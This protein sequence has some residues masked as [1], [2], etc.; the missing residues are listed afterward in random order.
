MSS[1]A[2]GIERISRVVGYK[3]TKGNFATLSTNLPQR[4]A[5]LGE[6]NNANQSSL[7]LDPIQITSL[8]QAGVL[9]GYGSPI[10]A[11]LRIL[12]PVNGGG[13]GGIPVWVYPQEEAAGA[14]AKIVE[15]EVSGVATDN[16]T[17]TIVIGGRY[18]MDG[19]SYDISIVAGDTQAEINAKIED[20]INNVLGSPMGAASTDYESVLTTKWNGLTAQDVN[21]SIDTNDRAV[22]LTY[23]VTQTQAGSGTP[24]IDDALALFANN[25]NTIVI[26]T[27]GTVSAIMTSL[28]SFNGIP[29]PDNPT[30]RYVGNIMKPFIA[31]TGSVA[32]D[33]SSITDTRE[34]QVTIAICPAPLSEG[35]PLEAAA[36]MCVL[37]AVKEQSS[38]HLD[39]AGMSYPDM[40]TPTDIGTMGE[41]Y[42]NRDVIVKKGCSTVDLVAGKYQVQDFVTTYH[43][44][45]EIP[46]QF[47]YC[48]N[49]MLDFNIRYKY[50]L[51]EQIFVVDKAIASNDQIITVGNVI[52]PKD[53]LGIINTFADDLG[54]AGLI[55]DVDFMKDSITVELSSSNPDRLETFFRYKR[56][57]IARISATTAEAGF[58]FGTVQ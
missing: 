14:N 17:H 27:Y 50:F 45:G 41:N 6:A 34:D 2:I 22:G 26:N 15:I 36:N 32:D 48:R 52:K 28:E 3:I 55:A 31:L 8:R 54:A 10:Y 24:D 42:N 53:W 37:F 11:A 7:S 58:N 38:P 23:T 18:N 13:I 16:A 5:I 19:A 40:P 57:G 25:W 39:V 9:F 29:D 51:L 30:G 12:M 21:V 49:L 33:P 56:T 46:P 1:D 20:A 43:P 44:L 4:I 35:H 47:R